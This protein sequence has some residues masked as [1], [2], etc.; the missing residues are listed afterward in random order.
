MTLIVRVPGPGGHLVA[1]PEHLAPPPAP[2][3]DTR[4]TVATP[5]PAPVPEP[6]LD[7]FATLIGE[8]LDNRA[9]ILAA[10]PEPPMTRDEIIDCLSLPARSIGD[11]VQCS[12]DADSRMIDLLSSDRIDRLLADAVRGHAAQV[13]DSDRDIRL[14]KRLDR[15]MYRL[16]L[17]LKGLIELMYIDR[18]PAGAVADRLG[19]SMRQLEQMRREALTMLAGLMR[20]GIG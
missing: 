20:Q 8:L 3:E 4:P 12:R 14:I 7:D 18:L 2:V 15:Q 17:H 10:T 16:P 13:H 9:S 11:R 19:A 1:T 6:Q 5:Q